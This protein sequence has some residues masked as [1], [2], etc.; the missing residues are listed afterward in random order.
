MKTQDALPTAEETMIKLTRA[1]DM[2]ALH[3][4]QAEIVAA[5]GDAWPK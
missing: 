5:Q 1:I 4:T 3:R 2:Q